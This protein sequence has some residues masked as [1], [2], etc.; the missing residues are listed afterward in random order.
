MEEIGQHHAANGL[1]LGKELQDTHWK[2]GW[3][4]STIGLDSLEK[5]MIT[6]PC[7]DPNHNSS[8]FQLSHYTN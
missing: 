8:V 7:R 2:G 6:D 4:W 5:R 3:K 1:H